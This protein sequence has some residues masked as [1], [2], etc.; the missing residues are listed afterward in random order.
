MKI[1]N[2]SKISAALLI[3][4]VLT[5]LPV[6]GTY[7]ALADSTSSNDSVSNDTHEDRILYEKVEYIAYDDDDD[8]DDDSSSTDS[9]SD[10]SSSSGSDY[11]SASSSSSYIVPGATWFTPTAVH[12]ENVIVVLPLV[13]MLKENLTDVVVTPVVSEQT[14]EFP[15]E[16]FSTGFTQKIDTLVGEKA[17]KDRNKRAQNCVWAFKTRD[18]VKSGYY[19]INYNV[20]YT[21]PEGNSESCT[22][23]TYVKTEGLAKYGTT[24]GYEDPADKSTPRI[25]VTGFTTS[26]SEVYAGD[27]FTLN[28][29]IKNTSKRTAVNNLQLDLTA[30]VAGKDESSSYAAFLPSSGSNSFYLDS[31]PAGGEQVLSMDFTAKADLEQK[32][33]VMSIKMNYENDYAVAFEGSAEVSIPVKQI[34]KF[35]TSSITAEPS[36]ISVGEQTNLMFNI[37]NTGKTKLYNVSVSVNGASIEPT[38]GFVGGLASGATGNVDMMITGTS[39]TMDDGNIE[40]IISYEDENGNVTSTVKN[41]TLAVTADDYSYDDIDYGDETMDY[42]GSSSKTPI[43]IGVSAGIVLVII[44]IVVVRKKLA[45]KKELENEDDEDI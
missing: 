14:D 4:S 15:F 7:I 13:N 42:E 2:L 9:T 26:P 17:E 27:S 1:I 29:N 31:L 35:D 19:K 5:A 25:I 21:N 40:A 18:D 6:C 12:G 41:F 43:I 22:V 10:D 11:S 24:S 37:Y 28:L 8:D 38:F 16:I 20:L 23:S 34:S 3:A 39:E 30:V 33:Y 45:A 32:P 44:L 36:S